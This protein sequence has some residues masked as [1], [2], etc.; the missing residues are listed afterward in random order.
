M[1]YY[2]LK[3]KLKGEVQERKTML[4]ALEEIEGLNSRIEDAI[5][6]FDRYDIDEL[7]D[8]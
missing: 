7:D 5:A 4:R 6:S 3:Q 1:E 8:F 2:S